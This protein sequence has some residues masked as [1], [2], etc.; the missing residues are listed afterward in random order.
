MQNL[1][2]NSTVSGDPTRNNFLPLL[3]LINHCNYYALQ[4][5]TFLESTHYDNNVLVVQNRN[6][7]QCMQIIERRDNQART[8][9]VCTLITCNHADSE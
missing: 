9:A 3:I 7:K 6:C 8:A 4:K 1:E 5:Q 2:T